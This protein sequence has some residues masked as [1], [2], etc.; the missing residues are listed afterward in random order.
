MEGRK[1]LAEKDLKR[2]WRIPENADGKTL[3]A[4]IDSLLI[5]GDIQK[6]VHM[7]LVPSLVLDLG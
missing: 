7:S 4:Y 1:K 6:P 2:F 3:I 5:K